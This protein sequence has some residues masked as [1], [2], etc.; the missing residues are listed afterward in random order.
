[1]WK[2]VDQVFKAWRITSNSRGDVVWLEENRLTEP[3]LVR[4]PVGGKAQA[5]G[6]PFPLYQYHDMAFGRDDSLYLLCSVKAS[7]DTVLKLSPQGTRIEVPFT[8]KDTLAVA[9]DSVISLAATGGVV[10]GGPK[11]DPQSRPLNTT[12]AARRNRS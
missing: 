6:D 4:L 9:F 7:K 8:G 10:R 1:M 2:I 5:F 3:S 12:D 11:E